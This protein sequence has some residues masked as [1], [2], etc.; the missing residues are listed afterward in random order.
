MNNEPSDDFHEAFGAIFGNDWG[1]P[2][3]PKAAP[4]TEAEVESSEFA[5]F[6]DRGFELFH[7]QQFE[8]SAEAFSNAIKIAA[9]FGDTY[10]NRA[11]CYWALGGQLDQVR[12]D[13]KQ[14]LNLGGQ[15]T[16]QDLLLLGQVLFAEERPDKAIEVVN[17]ANDRLGTSDPAETH[18]E[19]LRQIALYQHHLGDSETALNSINLALSK[20]SVDSESL[21]LRGKIY[22]HLQRNEEAIR[23]F[24]A[25]IANNKGNYKHYLARAEANFALLGHDSKVFSDLDVCFALLPDSPSERFD[26]ARQML[27]IGTDHPGPIL[28]ELI[29]YNPDNTDILASRAYFLSSRDPRK[30]LADID[31]A[32]RLGADDQADVFM[33]QGAIL[34]QVDRPSDA[35]TAFR[36]AIELEP[37]NLDHRVDLGSL[38]VREREFHEAL[39]CFEFVLQISPD[40]ARALTGRASIYFELGDFDSAIQDA[41]VAISMDENSLE[42]YEFRGAAYAENG[43]YDA[44]L[45]DLERA[46]SL[47]PDPAR[48]LS[49]IACL[50]IECGQTEDAAAIIASAETFDPNRQCPD[51]SY[52]KAQ[53]DFASERFESALENIRRAIELDPSSSDYIVLEGDVLSRLNR[54]PEARQSYLLAARYE[55]GNPY[56]TAL[57]SEK[58]EQG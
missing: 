55:E 38:L 30:A 49:F 56:K 33:L 45:A 43:N 34:A 21:E 27:E 18:V 4:L 23:D 9:T 46:R 22:L 44:A 52:A 16:V 42:A 54:G 20:L 3:R 31:R 2:D 29:E 57:I 32:I 1:Q 53:L 6:Y 15:N 47:A 12:E 24:D 36:K 28:D 50:K 40:Y 25:A 41:T 39:T 48:C 11:R 14:A 13:L 19:A 10:S 17:L 51:L 8:E 37:S 26:A 35:A 5:T 7:Q 58:F